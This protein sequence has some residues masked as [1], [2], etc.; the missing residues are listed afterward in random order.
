MVINSSRLLL[1][2]WFLSKVFFTRGCRGLFYNYSLGLFSSIVSCQ[3]LFFL[4]L[5][6]FF[7]LFEI[8][9]HFCLGNIFNIGIKKMSWCFSFRMDG[10]IFLLSWKKALFESLFLTARYH[11]EYYVK[12]S[13]FGSINIIIKL[14]FVEILSKKPS[15]FFFECFTNMFM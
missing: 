4:K 5:I 8:F 3:S 7:P 2:D 10:K 9:L 14:I 11:A 15:L 12:I 6:H 1:E 13:L